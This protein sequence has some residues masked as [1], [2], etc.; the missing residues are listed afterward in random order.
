HLSIVIPAYNEENRLGETLRRVAEYLDGQRFRAEVIVV[1][2]GSTDGTVEVARASPGKHRVLVND[3]N[4]GKGYSVRRG[5]LEA[6][7]D[8]ILF[9]DA[10]LSAPIDEFDKLRRAIENGADVAIGSRAMPDSDIQIHQPWYRET[11][12]KTF[13]FLVRSLVFPGV[14]DTQ[15][16]F[17][18]FTGASAREIFGRQTL[19]GFAFDVEILYIAR[20]LGYRVREVPVVWRDSP[21]TRVGALSDSLAMFSDIIRIRAIHS[22]LRPLR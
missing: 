3:G 20:R 4:R 18:A 22:R 19:P 10:D 11:M 21:D 2:D 6:Q 15:C 16:G 9:T 8:L 13:N 14:S 7:G 17:K 12:G 1:D 5:A